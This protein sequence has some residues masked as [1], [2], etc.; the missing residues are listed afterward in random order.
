M[1]VQ[2]LQGMMSGRSLAFCLIVLTPLF[3]NW[4]VRSTER[5]KYQTSSSHISSQRFPGWLK[6]EKCSAYSTHILIALLL[7]VI[8][9]DT[10][11]QFHRISENVSMYHLWNQEDPISQCREFKK[12]EVEL[13]SVQVKQVATLEKNFLTLSVQVCKY[14]LNSTY[15]NNSSQKN[16][17]PWMGLRA[18]WSTGRYQ[19]QWQGLELNDCKCPF[20]LKPFYNSMR[21]CM[22][23]KMFLNLIVN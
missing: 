5:I 15:R 14:D 22:N 9:L 21:D 2:P 1:K 17:I 16:T 4:L 23:I 7:H 12:I 11:L 8:S 13:N 19:C 20:H 10:F 6:K 3:L 18:T